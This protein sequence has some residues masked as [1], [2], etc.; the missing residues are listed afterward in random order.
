[1]ATSQPA[2]DITQS[3]DKLLKAYISYR[4]IHYQPTHH[5]IKNE[6]VSHIDY[7]FIGTGQKPLKRGFTFSVL[8]SK[9]IIDRYSKD[10]DFYKNIYMS[11]QLFSKIINKPTYQPTRETVM[12]CCIGLKLTEAD[13]E[14]LMASAGHAFSPAFDLDLVIKMCLSVRCYDPMV[15]D[16]LLETYNVKPLFAHD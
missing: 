7:D 8:L 13:A 4:L 15:I 9:L 11:R 12:K 6:F 5:A 16:Q 2:G 3:F 10:P 1:M 14:E